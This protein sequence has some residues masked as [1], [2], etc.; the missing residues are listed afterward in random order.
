MKSSPTDLEVLLICSFIIA[1]FFNLASIFL[2]RTILSINSLMAKR[3]YKLE[4]DRKLKEK[5]EMISRGELHEWVT[6]KDHTMEVMVCKKTGWV[7]D[8]KIF[9]PL[10][11]VKSYLAQDN[12]KKDYEAAKQKEIEKLSLKLNLPVDVIDRVYA[13]LLEHKKDFYVSF[14]KQQNQE[15]VKGESEKN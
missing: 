2:K 6:I 3:R 7:P 5:D 14:M 10:P 4:Y 11:M 8:K 1:I 12:V 9:L 15:A 13:S